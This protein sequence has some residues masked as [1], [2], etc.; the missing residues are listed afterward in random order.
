M[1]VNNLQ[2]KPLL[3]VG[4]VSG[5]IQI[6]AGVVMYLG[7][8]YFSPWS[9]VVSR[10]V[11]LACIVVGTRWYVRRVLGGQSMYL[12]AL[13]IGMTITVCTAVLYMIY[14]V[15]TISWL[16]PRFLGDMARAVPGGQPPTLSSVVAANF[17]GFCLV[18][19]VISALTA[20]AFR[21]RGHARG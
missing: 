10:V 20:I 1:T 16:Y 14:N 12:S 8:V 2:W 17:M 18:G 9:G 19:T 13:L 6:A 15:V 21:R 5:L 3:R 7:G 11:L 4:A